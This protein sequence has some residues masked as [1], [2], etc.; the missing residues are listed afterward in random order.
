VT[1][2]P[3]SD[4]EFT[5]RFEAARKDCLAGHDAGCTYGGLT[6]SGGYWLAAG[7]RPL[8]HGDACAVCGGVPDAAFRDWASD[9][10]WLQIWGVW[11]CSGCQSRELGL[12]PEKRLA[13]GAVSE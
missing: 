3:V 12:H 9:G 5:S 8:S 4:E 7:G 1:D 2:A 6:P 13:P 11:L 10:G